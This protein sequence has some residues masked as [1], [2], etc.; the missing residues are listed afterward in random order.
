MQT[1]DDDT[2]RADRK[3]LDDLDRRIR[4][5]AEA[6]TSRVRRQS[7]H[8]TAA[9]LGVAWRLSLELVAAVGIGGALGFGLDRLLGVTPLMTLVGFGFG[10]AA[11][12]RNVFRAAAEMSAASA[13]QD[14]R[15]SADPEESASD[16]DL[17]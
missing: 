3:R 15:R 5:R 14:A 6:R 12:V 1:P 16:D 7:G 17:A 10:F 8:A 2:A 11:G 13:A 4:E 9:G